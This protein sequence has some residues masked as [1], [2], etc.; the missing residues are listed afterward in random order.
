MTDFKTTE[1]SVK[2][3]APGIG[4]YTAGMAGIVLFSFFS[5]LLLPCYSGKNWFMFQIWSI[6]WREV[7][8]DMHRLFAVIHILVGISIFL[9]IPLLISR[10]VK[11]ASRIWEKLSVGVVIVLGIIFLI[12]GFLYEDIFIYCKFG[13][14]SVAVS[15]ALGISLG[16]V[17]LAVCVCI[18][19]FCF[20]EARCFRYKHCG[21]GYGIAVSGALFA[22]MALLITYTFFEKYNYLRYPAN[23]PLLLPYLGVTLFV[24]GLVRLYGLLLARR[25]NR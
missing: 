21:Y 9:I 22:M 4:A 5:L 10:S 1:D 11:G 17:L 14:Q 20:T 6:L 7:S 15:M 19:G 2:I 8:R 18:G 3:P 23:I 12:H 16:I 24:F 13:M 25:A